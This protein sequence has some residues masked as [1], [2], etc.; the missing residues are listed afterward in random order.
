MSVFEWMTLPYRRYAE[1]SGRSRRKEY[2]L[3]VLFYFVLSA[4]IDGVFGKP[5]SQSGPFGFHYGIW[6]AKGTPGYWVSMV[7]S[8]GSI[9]P[10]IAVQ[11]RR[12]HDVDRSG[13]WMLLWFVPV[14]GWTVM[15]VFLCLD[16]TR[17]G[18]SY[19]FDPKGRGV[20]E[21]FE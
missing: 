14:L 21:V 10:S 8:L 17:G 3:F 16:G 1:F 20:A 15:L 7:V 11:V 2:W 5:V 4:V 18:N 6:L 9:I 19:G 13:W 12:L